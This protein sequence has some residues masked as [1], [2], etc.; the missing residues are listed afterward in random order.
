MSHLKQISEI[1]GQEFQS[2]VGNYSVQLKKL[3]SIRFQHFTSPLTNRAFL[4]LLEANV[5]TEDRAQLYSWATLADQGG[6]S[7]ALAGG[8]RAAGPRRPG[9]ATTPKTW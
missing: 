6:G 5:S 9:Q 4:C 3:T 7:V 8:R 1:H 2:V